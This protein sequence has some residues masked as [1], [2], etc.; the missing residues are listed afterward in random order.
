MRHP[1]PCS[2]QASAAQPMPLAAVARKQKKQQL[3]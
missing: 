1:I 2:V 3:V